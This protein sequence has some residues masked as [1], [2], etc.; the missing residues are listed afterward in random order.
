[1][2]MI[3]VTPIDEMV[4]NKLVVHPSLLINPLVVRKIESVELEATKPVVPVIAVGDK[5]PLAEP[6]V[7]A[8]VP[9][10]PPLMVTLVTFMDGKAMHIKEDMTAVKAMGV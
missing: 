5:E 10:V 3:S 9:P 1:M 6:P 4:G 7:T 2:P 8:P